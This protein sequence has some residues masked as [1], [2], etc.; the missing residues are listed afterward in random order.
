LA[1]CRPHGADALRRGAEAL[2][3]GRSTE[4]IT[5][6]EQAVTDLPS[7][8]RAWNHLGL[9]YHAAGRD[10]EA[11]KS[12]LRALERNRGFLEAWFNVG[13]LQFEQGNWLEAER[14]LR[15]YLGAET[16]RTNSV[17]WRTLGLAQLESNQLDL[18]ERSLA[19]ATKLAPSDAEAWNGVGLTQ[20]SRRRFRDALKTFNYIAE[21]APQHAP[22]RLNAAVITHQ[23]LSDRRGAI[24]LYRA[25]LALKPANAAEV[26]TLV[27][28]LEQSLPPP[29]GTNAPPPLSTTNSLPRVST[30]LIS[31]ATNAPPK[32]APNSPTPV[33]PAAAPKPSVTHAPAVASTVTPPAAAPVTPKA[34]P[35][36][37]EPVLAP[38]P[39]PEPE[40]VRLAPEPKLTVARDVK[41]L[42]PPASNP[43]TA[44]PQPV[45]EGPTGLPLATPATPPTPP[46]G[47][48]ETEAEAERRGFWRRANP[49]SWN[50]RR[51]NPGTWFSGGESEPADR[52]ATPLATPKPAARGTLALP[53]EAPA[54]KAAPSG[55]P[56]RPKPVLPRYQPRVATPVAPG[57]RAKAEVAFNAAILGHSRR[58]LAGAAALY[59]QAA[60][61]DPTFYPAHHNLALTAL[62]L[63]DPARAV[64]AAEVATALQ[65]ASVASRQLFATA[66]QRANYPAD[67]AEQWEKIL[68]VTP[69]EASVHLHLA[70][71]FAT[72]LGEPAKARPHY[73]RVLELEPNHPQASAIRIWLAGNP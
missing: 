29:A 63:N 39:E 65:P 48:A 28:Q 50:W 71:L 68:A 60:Q 41:P 33:A 26:A 44:T 56:A 51:A 32:P 19:T 43:P 42:A 17:A 31:R 18:A 9:A 73:L 53:T 54:T 5:L 47:A 30:N 20:V 21:V 11:L 13:L 64:A 2:R 14:A 49:V 57:N 55:P 59:E 8:A 1:G 70:G 40:V 25:Y 37:A 6:L 38:R 15:T 23:H 34:K 7:E 36:P 10:H 46:A 22:A 24:P 67:A 35:K 45:T 61:A 16:S 27:S 4:A 66:L 12:H 3:A 72:S 69:N 62:D 52:P 58:D